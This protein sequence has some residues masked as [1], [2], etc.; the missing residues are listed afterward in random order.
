MQYTEINVDTNPTC[1]HREVNPRTASCGN[2]GELM[3]GCTITSDTVKS[4]PNL[5]PGSGVYLP[6][7]RNT[8]EIEVGF[9]YQYVCKRCRLGPDTTITADGIHWSCGQNH[10]AYELTGERSD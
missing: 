9:E 3:I 10:S 6:D 7:I 1:Q 2:C 5:V 8:R 4:A